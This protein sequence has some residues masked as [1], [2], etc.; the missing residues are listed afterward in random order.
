MRGADSR[1]ISCIRNEICGITFEIRQFRYLVKNGTELAGS[2]LLSSFFSYALISVRVSGIEAYT[3][4]WSPSWLVL[5]VPEK[6]AWVPTRLGS[7]SQSFGLSLKS[8]IK[9]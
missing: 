4:Y 2:R 3:K 7:V 6:M 8:P 9:M 1:G 5:F